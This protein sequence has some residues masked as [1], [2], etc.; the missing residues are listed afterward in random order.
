MPMV[1]LS[2]TPTG[3]VAHVRTIGKIVGA[4]EPNHQLIQE[5]SFIAGAPRG[6]KCCAV[7][8]VQTL[9][10]LADLLIGFFPGDR[11]IVTGTRAQAHRL[12]ESPLGVE[13]VI[14]LFRQLLHAVTGKER[15]IDPIF[16]GFISDGAG[17]IFT[18]LGNRPVFRIGPC[19]SRAIKSRP[20]IDLEQGRKP[21]ADARPL[22]RV[23]HARGNRTQ[24]GSR[25]DIGG[26]SLAPC[27]RRA[28][29]HW[30]STRASAVGT[31]AV[32]FATPVRMQ[33]RPPTNQGSGL[34]ARS[35]T[36]AGSRLAAALGRLD[37]P[38]KVQ[39]VSLP[40]IDPHIECGGCVSWTARRAKKETATI[41]GLADH[42]QVVPTQ[43]CTPS[44]HALVGGFFD[45]ERQRD[46][47][48]AQ[49]RR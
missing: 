37:Q 32:V 38:T 49:R 43:R 33:P 30:G 36:S 2:A 48:G 29:K 9:Q 39:D 16:A 18:K 31:I 34:S 44:V 24:A 21:A 23:A 10:G 5:R 14:A 42:G 1:S 13:P 8:I 35:T 6:V 47:T 40:R 46:L 41:V 4:V 3:F 11:L 25:T 7:G 15:G 12:T 17:T 22:D 45:R 26:R 20:L 28:S 27:F 19:T